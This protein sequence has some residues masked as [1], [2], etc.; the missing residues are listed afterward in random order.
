MDVYIREKRS[1]LS[2]DLPRAIADLPSRQQQAATAFLQYEAPRKRRACSAYRAARSSRDS[3]QHF[4]GSADSRNG[5]LVRRYQSLVLL[6]HEHRPRNRASPGH[7]RSP[8]EQICELTLSL[9]V[10]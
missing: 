4:G 1:R 7:C 10:P 6:V 5:T 3:R 2:G 8:Q 9:L